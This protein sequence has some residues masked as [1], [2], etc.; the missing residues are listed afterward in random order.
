MP[1]NCLD[2]ASEQAFELFI[3][4]LHRA[5]IKNPLG[6]RWIVKDVS[7]LLYSAMDIGLTQRDLFRFIKIYDDMSLRDAL[8]NNGAFW[9][10]AQKRALSMHKKLGRVS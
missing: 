2:V 6:L 3:I 8:E 7:G 10:A 1:K 9:S 5:L 4:D